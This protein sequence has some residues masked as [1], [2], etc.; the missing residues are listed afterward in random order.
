M[1]GDVG[2]VDADSYP[3]IV[4]CGLYGVSLTCFVYIYGMNRTFVN[5]SL[6][7]M[8]RFGGFPDVAGIVVDFFDANADNSEDLLVYGKNGPIL[9]SSFYMRRSNA[10]FQ[11]LSLPAVFGIAAIQLYNLD[12][13]STGDLNGDGI[14]DVL[15]MYSHLSGM[16]NHIYLGNGNGTYSPFNDSYIFGASFEVD[17]PEGA[18]FD[19]DNNGYIDIILSGTSAS[20][21]FIS[22]HLNN[23]GMNF[24]AFDIGRLP[25]WLRSGVTDASYAF[26]DF[27][28][29]SLVDMALLGSMPVCGSTVVVIQQSPPVPAA[30]TS[31]SGDVSLQTVSSNDLPLSLG[32]LLGIII[33][34]ASGIGLLMLAAL[35][36]VFLCC[37]VCCLCIV[38]VAVALLLI[39]AV[40]FF[41]V[42]AVVG[43]GGAA[44]S[45]SFFARGSNNGAGA[46]VHKDD[47]AW[48]DIAIRAEDFDV[49]D[50]MDSFNAVQ[51]FKKIPYS[52]LEIKSKIGEGGFGAVYRADWFGSDVALKLLR[53]ESL[54]QSLVDEFQRE[55][56]LMA[57]V[58]HHPNIVGFIGAVMSAD[59]VGIVL[60][61]CPLGSLDEQLRSSKISLVQKL[62]IALGVLSGLAFLHLNG[63]IHRDL[64]A[65]NILLHNGMR[66]VIC[67]FGLSRI[68]DADSGNDAGVTKSNVG[69]VRWMAPEALTAR[70]Y[71]AATDLYS[72]GVLLWELFTDGKTP[73]GTLSVVEVIMFVSRQGGRP[74]LDAVSYAPIIPI[75]KSLW[76][77]D[78]NQRPTI[79]DLRTQ[80]RELV[81]AEEEDSPIRAEAE[82]TSSSEP[83]VTYSSMASESTDHSYQS[84]DTQWAL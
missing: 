46:K 59:R 41:I 7:A 83:S 64:A 22:I 81:V 57:K 4:N 26:A 35:A 72:F 60:E 36:I 51:S 70:M 14:S 49:T 43:G 52:D 34:G 13:I 55:A 69:P 65:R 67:D 50:F 8:E 11:R 56:L 53:S 19:I 18:L 27:N 45:V 77:T 68:C 23:G 25:V 82:T 61:F 75:L 73:F 20:A 29:D 58:S 30:T 15:L 48:L 10:T 37:I 79:A 78:P 62:H 74:D 32:A 1:R 3:D 40:I 21:A 80:L 71:S 17:E 6:S 5:D 28:N 44:A 33:G 9:D 2:F 47:A 63:I 42:A 31:T 24:S 38:I 76:M 84:I 12:G 54:D 66:P 16:F 39:V